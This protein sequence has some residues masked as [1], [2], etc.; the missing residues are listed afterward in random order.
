MIERKAFTVEELI[1]HLSRYQKDM[2]VGITWEG[3]MCGIYSDSFALEPYDGTT[4]VVIDAND[5]NNAG[6][7]IL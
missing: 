7:D 1:N 3:V 2:Q 4:L 5:Y 6:R